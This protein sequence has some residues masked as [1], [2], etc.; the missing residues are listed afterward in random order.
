MLSQFA[1]PGKLRTRKLAGMYDSRI[2]L[3]ANMPFSASIYRVQG[4]EGS[5]TMSYM[6]SNTNS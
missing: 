4:S 5:Y 6:V 3:N 2:M 1:L